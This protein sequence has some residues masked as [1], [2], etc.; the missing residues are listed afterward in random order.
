LAGSG[1]TAAWYIGLVNNTS[2]ST[3]FSGGDTLASARRLGRE[4]QL[5]WQPQGSQLWLRPLW[6]IR[7]EHQ[8]RIVNRVKFTMTA[9]AAISGAFPT[10]VATGTSGLLFSVSDFQSPGDRQVVSGD[11]LNA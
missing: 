4:L 9:N 1:Y 10:N 6:Q 7:I 8:Q 5:L 11:V 2:A 3:T